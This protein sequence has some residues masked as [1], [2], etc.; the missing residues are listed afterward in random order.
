MRDTS[1]MATHDDFA[2]DPLI[3]GSLQYREMKRLYVNE[4]KQSDEWRKD[5]H[6][7]KRQLAELRAKTIRKLNVN[8]LANRD[9]TVVGDAEKRN[10]LFLRIWNYSFVLARPTAEVAEWLQELFDLLSA[11]NLFKGDGRSLEQ[12]AEDLGVDQTTSIFVAARTPQKSALKLFRTLYPT[13]GSRA[14]CRS[15]SKVPQKQLDDI[16][17]MFFF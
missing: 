4:K 16:Y 14:N 1:N 8:V 17:R 3:E 11:G 6:I 13:I 10:I 5:Y 12:I 7:L 2:L 9:Y 15:I